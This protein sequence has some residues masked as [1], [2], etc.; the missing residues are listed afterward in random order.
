[1]SAGVCARAGCIAIP[2]EN[3]HGFEL[4]HSQGISACAATLVEFLIDP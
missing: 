2:T 1:M 3:T 4:I